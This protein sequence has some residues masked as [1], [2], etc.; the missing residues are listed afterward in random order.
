MYVHKSHDLREHGSSGAVYAVY[1]RENLTGMSSTAEVWAEYEETRVRR[2][3]PPA[4]KLLS[5]Y[6]LDGK[7]RA[8]RE[9]RGGAA[10]STMATLTPFKLASVQPWEVKT[11]RQQ[12]RH[13][14][15]R[16]I[17]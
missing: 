16:T 15:D 12:W 5:A 13:L 11:T 7:Y 14:V 17:D 8:Q 9:D 4:Q 10:L 6:V 1:T 3:I 2:G